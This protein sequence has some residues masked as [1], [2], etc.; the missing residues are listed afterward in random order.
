LKKPDRYIRESTEE[1]HD[2]TADRD[3]RSRAGEEAS[4]PESDAS[5]D[6]SCGGKLPPDHPDADIIDDLDL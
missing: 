4:N 6:F 2:V 1:D 3:S 5:L